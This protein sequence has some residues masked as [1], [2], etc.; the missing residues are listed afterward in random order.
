MTT[1]WPA[2]WPRRVN[3]M[4]SRREAFSASAKNSS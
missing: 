2:D 4:S 3:V 1:G